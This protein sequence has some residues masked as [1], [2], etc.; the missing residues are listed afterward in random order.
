MAEFDAIA[1]RAEQEGQS[2]CLGVLSLQEEEVIQD[3]LED[4]AFACDLRIASRS[5][6]ERLRTGEATTPARRA[7]A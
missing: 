4:L 7:A 5:D 1:A 2:L 3:A 6:L